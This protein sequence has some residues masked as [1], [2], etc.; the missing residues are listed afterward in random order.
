MIEKNYRVVFDLDGV[1]CETKKDGQEYTDLKPNIQVLEKLREYK[2]KGFY[3]ILYTGR[4][5]NTYTNNLGKINA[6]TAKIIFEWLDKYEIPYD[7]IYFGKPWCGFKGF[8]VD[9]K[10]IRPSEFIS[11][12][13]KEIIKLLENEKELGGDKR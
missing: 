1:L 12:S 8:Y 10:A 4:N 11:K 9:D 5:M 13:Y 6:H 2:R 3:I 7:E